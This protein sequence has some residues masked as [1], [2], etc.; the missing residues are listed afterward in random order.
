MRRKLGFDVIELWVEN[1]V[2]LEV[3]TDYMRQEYLESTTTA[4]WHAAMEKCKEAQAPGAS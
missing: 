1:R 4:R 2:M 3:L